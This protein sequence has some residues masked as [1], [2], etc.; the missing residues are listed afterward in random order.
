MTDSFTWCE[1]CDHHRPANHP[2]RD[3]CG[4]HPRLEG[5]GYVRKGEWDHFPPWLFCKDVNG[6][7]CSLFEP[8]REGED[9]A[10]A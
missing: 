8:K 2:A 4:K 6:G 10:K 9:D 3:M 1:S 7:A 5:F